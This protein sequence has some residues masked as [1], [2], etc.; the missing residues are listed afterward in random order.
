[1]KP[2]LILFCTV[3]ETLNFFKG[4]LKYLSRS[5]NIRV[6][7][8]P[9][10]K[11][12]EFCKS[13]EVSG[14]PIKMF[15]EVNVVQDALSLIKVLV[16]LLKEKPDIVHANTP[17]ASLLVMIASFIIRIPVRIYYC[18]GLRYQG[19]HKNGRFFLMLI[20][21]LTCYLATNIYAVSFGLSETIKQDG[22]TKKQVKVIGNGSINGIDEFFFN[23]NLPEISISSDLKNRIQHKFVFGFIGRI[24]KDKG[25]IELLES[26]KRL[27]ADNKD[28]LLLLIGSLELSP[29]IDSDLIN[30]IN[31][32][33]SIYYVGY[34]SDV[35]PYYKAMDVLVFP[36]Y[37]EG[38]GVSLM[39]AAKMNVPSIATDIIGCNEVIEH[40]INGLLVEP[41]SIE[42]L[43]SAMSVLINSP[44]LL[45]PM[46]NKCEALVSKKFSQKEL[47]PV[48][49]KTFVSLLKN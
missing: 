19:A 47:W 38:F 21:R 29:S 32:N 49:E 45:V 7:A 16:L 13:E 40:G 43:Y 22:I 28:I 37:R 18:H 5:F 27:K 44:S 12:I 20:E 24:T 4:Q 23:S 26:F 48:I 10:S 42:S 33:S 46:R 2:K 31:S 1:M 35:R 15:R 39:E 36:S 9:G 34:R 6:V 30:E 14:T 11:F 3:P 25:I 8:S 41:R 17:K